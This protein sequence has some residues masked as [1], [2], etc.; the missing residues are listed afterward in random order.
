MTKDRVLEAII[1]F[2]QE[3]ELE[4]LIERLIFIENVESGLRQLEKG[5]TVSHDEV[6]K[7]AARG[8]N[9]VDEFCLDDRW[10]EKYLN[11]TMSSSGSVRKKLQN[12]L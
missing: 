9:K 7:I 1:E 3:F 4:E 2:P 12:H 6:K 5:E 11:L 10:A 8:K